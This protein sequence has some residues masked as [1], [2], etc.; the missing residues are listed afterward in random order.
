MSSI[1]F[2]QF[3]DKPVIH[4][5][6]P[7]GESRLIIW[8]RSELLEF[9]NTGTHFL[10]VFD[11]SAK[12]RQ[13]HSQEQYC[14]CL[15]GQFYYAAIPGQF[16]LEGQGRGIVITRFNHFGLFSLGGPVE[17]EG[18]LR[19]ID[20]CTDTLIIPP[21]RIGDPCLNLLFIPRGTQQ[22]N[23]THPSSRM[24]IVIDGEG[25]CR[26]PTEDTL[27]KSGTIFHIPENCQHSFHTDNHH[28]KVIAYHPDSD[29]GPD[30]Q[31]HP[32]V[33]R[34]FVQGIPANRVPRLLT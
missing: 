8:D 5:K 4:H 26:T 24:G 3:N 14:D 20:G 19:Y 25:I 9:D 27:I 32:M 23:H 31:N 17:A 28:L 18:R 21:T 15:I 7:L 6:E 33:N 16:T 34:T 29:C 13:L 22:T 11:G 30:D 12:V 1:A 10:F 2:F